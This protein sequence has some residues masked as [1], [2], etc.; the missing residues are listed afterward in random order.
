[1]TAAFLDSVG[2]FVGSIG[3]PAAIAFFILYQI[4]PKLDTIAVQQTQ[5]NTT[6]SLIAASCAPAGIVRPQI[7]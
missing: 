6:L 4:G 3:V 2:R 5:A 7:P 1:M